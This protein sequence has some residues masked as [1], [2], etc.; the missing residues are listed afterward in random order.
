MFPSSEKK[1]REKNHSD[2]KNTGEKK[3]NPSKKAFFKKAPKKVK[4]Q[5]AEKTV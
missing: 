5:N 4:I 3:K 1:E 2:L